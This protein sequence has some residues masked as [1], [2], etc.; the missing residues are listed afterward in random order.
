MFSNSVFCQVT[1]FT[2]G[3]SSG[4][5]PDS[6]SASS[7]TEDPISRGSSFDGAGGSSASTKSHAMREPLISPFLDL[8]RRHQEDAVAM[9]RLGVDYH[10]LNL[11]ELLLRQ[12]GFSSK[13]SKPS[14][15]SKHKNKN[16]SRGDR[17]DSGAPQVSSFAI[18][19]AWA[20][21]L[22]CQRKTNAQ[23]RVL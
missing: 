18:A 20:R 15:S 5:P 6:Q 7:S 17:T 1:V 19:K 13:T 9:D 3:E 10:Y 16:H 21:G 4:A 22:L 2:G 12:D 23:A 8:E 11:P 14:S